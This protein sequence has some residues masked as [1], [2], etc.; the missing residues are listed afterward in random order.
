MSTY[1]HLLKELDSNLAI[2]TLN[3]NPNNATAKAGVKA[4]AAQLAKRFDA[5]VKCTRSRDS[6]YPNFLVGQNFN[7]ENLPLIYG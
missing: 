6:S 1:C 3:R 2:A 7:A 4:F 5:K